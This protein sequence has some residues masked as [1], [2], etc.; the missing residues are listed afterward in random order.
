MLRARSYA[1]ARAAGSLGGAAEPYPAPM[2][3][4]PMTE[5]AYILV[6]AAHAHTA[7][8]VR[9]AEEE[10]WR[11]AAV[12]DRDPA[13]RAEWADRAGAPTVQRLA[14]A[15]RRAD[16][17]I[18][19][20][21][22]ADRAAQ[23]GGALVNGLPT[24]SEKPLAPDATTAATLA[25]VA[26]AK[27]VLLDIGFFLRTNPALAELRERVRAGAV[28]EALEARMR[29][30]HDGGYADWLDLSGWMSRP[31]RASYGGFGDEA[32]HALDWLLWT[33]GAPRAVSAQRSHALGLP[34]DDGGV[35]TLRFPN[36]ATGVAQGGWTDIRMR[37]ELDLVGEAGWAHVAD[38]RAAIHRRGA[39]EPVWTADLAPLDAGEG[40]RAFL[41]AVADGAQQGLTPPADAVATNA[42]LDRLYGR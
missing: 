1:S 40:A 37:L 2:R 14:D 36:G 5:R 29:F 19:C 26:A 33:L 30:G 39:S 25:R 23:V 27:G 10:G 42:L 17:A 24:F 13:R 16:A 32:I 21:E 18:V 7:D 3:P 35:A 11:C 34:V 22:T 12:L 38:G 4:Q 9:V 28:G 31:E 6:G 20:G 8:H 15:A 41:G